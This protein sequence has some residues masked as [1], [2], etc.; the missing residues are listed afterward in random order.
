M[1]NE[2]PKNLTRISNIHALEFRFH[3]FV[4]DKYLSYINQ[5]T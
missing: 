1:V 2:K 3:Y 4:P 5:D